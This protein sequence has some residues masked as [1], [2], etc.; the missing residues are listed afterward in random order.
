MAEAHKRRS[1]AGNFQADDS[2]PRP[3]ELR[4]MVMKLLEG[5]P[6]HDP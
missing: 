4:G 5:S 1:G 3:V 2:R 6:L